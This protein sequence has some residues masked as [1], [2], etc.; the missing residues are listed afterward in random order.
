METPLD[1][2]LNQFEA[3]GADTWQER[4]DA[5]RAEL[6]ALRAELAA[7]RAATRWVPV[8]ERLPPPTFDVRIFADDEVTMGHYDSTC[9]MWRDRLGEV[10]VPRDLV[11]HWQ[12]LPPAQGPAR[13]RVDGRQRRR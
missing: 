13:P 1:A 2:I 11:T 8:T 7:L 3:E 10:L 12:P 9:E 4:L 5:A 6:A